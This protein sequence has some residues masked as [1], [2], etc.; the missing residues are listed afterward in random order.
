MLVGG[1]HDSI[2]EPGRAAREFFI[3]P[4]V[5][6]LRI[7]IPLLQLRH[8]ESLMKLQYILRISQE[9]REFPG[10]LR[11]LGTLKYNQGAS[12]E[13]GLIVLQHRQH[14]YPPVDIGF[15]QIQMVPASVNDHGDLSGLERSCRC[16]NTAGLN[17]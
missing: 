4:A 8:P 17:R 12:E 13:E 10:F 5:D 2:L 3:C 16:R 1:T 14:T 9:F 11:M 7:F 6:Q 15:A